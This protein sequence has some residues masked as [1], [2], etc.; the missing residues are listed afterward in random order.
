M[1]HKHIRIFLPTLKRWF[2]ISCLST[3][4]LAETITLSP[5]DIYETAQNSESV[6]LTESEA[7]ETASIT[8][9]DRLEQDVSF[10]VVA[11][12]NGESTRIWLPWDAA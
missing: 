1:I 2:I 5:I 7:L 11:N 3:Y 9:Q 8:L 4:L 10:S 12:I 6:V